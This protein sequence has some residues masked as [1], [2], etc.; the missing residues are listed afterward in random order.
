MVLRTCFL[1]LI[2]LG[3]ALLVNKASGERPFRL[4]E[5]QG[6]IY[7]NTEKEGTGQKIL[8]EPIKTSKNTQAFKQTTNKSFPFTFFYPKE[9]ILAE[10][11]NLKNIGFEEYFTLPPLLAGEI[12]SYPGP[13]GNPEKIEKE[14]SLFIRILAFRGSL[15]NTQNWLE[16]YQIKIQKEKI[17]NENTTELIQYQALFGGNFNKV[18]LTS[19]GDIVGVIILQAQNEKDFEKGEEMLRTI[20]STF[21][22]L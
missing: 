6:A 8:L 13:L 15:A 9:L 19:N 4:T 1:I 22:W 14:W 12:Y 5:N 2:F 10:D 7:N 20:I 11:S 3:F 18:L 17:I 21:K 16:D